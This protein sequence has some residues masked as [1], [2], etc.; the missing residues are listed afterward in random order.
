MLQ[1]ASSYADA[2]RDFHW[3]I[4]E[5][6][7]IGVDVCDRHALEGRGDALIVVDERGSVRRYTFEEIRRLSNRLANLLRAR[8]LQRGDRVAVLLPQ[9]PETA[10]AHVAAF[11]A[12][13]ISVPLFTLFG[14]DALEYRLSNSGAKAVVTDTAGAEKLSAIRER[15]PELATVL[16]VGGGPGA[17][18]FA[19][20]L[21]RAS[22]DFVP[23]ETRADDPAVII[24]TSGTTGSPKGALHAHR[25]LLGHLP[26]VEVPHEF[27]PQP[28]DLF[29]TPADWAWIG[30]LF[31]VLMPA[32]HHGIPVLAHRA[33]KFDPDEAAHLMAA[34]GVRNVFI[35]PTALKLMRQVGLKPPAGLALRTVA[36]G[37]ETLGEE[38]LDWGRSTF[39]LTINEF[40][41]Q[42]ECNVIVANAAKLFPV[43]PGSMG[44]PVPGHDVC[45]VDEQGHPLPAGTVGTIAVR[46]PDP[47]MFLGYWNNDRAT[48]QKFAGEYLLTGDLGRTDD[49]GYLW[50][51][52]RSD[53]LI[54]SA[55][56]RIGPA[57]IEDCLIKHPA[58]AIA[59]VIGVPD[60]LRTEIVKAFIVLNPSHQPS[61]ALTAEIQEF[62]KR[63]LAAHEYP[64]RIE[65]V[66]SLPMT[67]TGKIMRRELRRREGG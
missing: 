23:V 45:V 13:L 14:E 30:G 55:G 42:T 53:D 47:V 2:Y 35:P 64:R 9:S 67:T 60:A 66:E 26:G 58:V 18:N 43:R 34:H 21:E 17:L 40:Y 6:Y 1:P 48:T 19:E 32:W 61:A 12:G 3:Q 27:F 50:F 25:V 65:F 36:S 38:L 56:Y 37:G 54:T 62:V 52:G 57:E 24:Y 8:G 59:A 4:P 31:D 63:R 41:G 46:R 29:W 51:L 49:D 20:Q 39:G 5:H 33:R 16:A 11:K 28:G 22:E 15:L 44:R 10:I 7:N